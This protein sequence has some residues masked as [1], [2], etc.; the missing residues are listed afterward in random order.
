MLYSIQLKNYMLKIKNIES[1]ILFLQII[2]Y[3]MNYSYLI[4]ISIWKF[5]EIKIE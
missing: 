1:D 2:I 5:I 4:M 3:Y